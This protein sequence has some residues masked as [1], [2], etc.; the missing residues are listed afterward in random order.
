[1]EPSAAL[2]HSKSYLA[3]IR[4]AHVRG[5][6]RGEPNAGSNVLDDVDGSQRLVPRTCVIACVSAALSFTDYLRSYQGHGGCQ[7]CLA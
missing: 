3:G 2:V 5:R 4:V 6:S 7:Y 1:M